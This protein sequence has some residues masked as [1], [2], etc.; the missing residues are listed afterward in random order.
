MYE[1]ISD[2]N[3]SPQSIMF[4]LHGGGYTAETWCWLV[5][6]MKADL[7]SLFVAYDLRGHGQTSGPDSLNLSFSNLCSDAAEIVSV[8]KTEHPSLPIFIVGHSL[9]GAIATAV[10]ERL[11]ALGIV[12][13]DI[14]EEAALSALRRMPQVL[15]ARPSKF[16]TE[17]DAVQWA[18]RS[19]TCS[20][21]E[22]AE[23]SFLSQYRSTENGLVQIVDLMPSEPHWDGWFRGLS[24]AFV[25][26]PANRLLVLAETDYLD[27]TLLIG[28]MQGKFQLEIVRN[29]GHAIQ[30]DQ[31]KLLA[32]LIAKF[33][34]RNLQVYCANHKA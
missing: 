2:S 3:S 6:Y 13:I 23:I 29:T 19:K 5:D 11:N 24:E 10:S 9:G 21:R 22:V 15:A 26:S 7:N 28:Q 4:L 33:V 17:E 32:S 27:K 1:A 34:K 12:V 8:Y 25:N 30:E 20:S 18:L 31:P 16:T 14:V